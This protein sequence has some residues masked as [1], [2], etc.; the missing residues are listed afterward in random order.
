MP[1]R[2]EREG[3]DWVCST[4][5]RV[6][7][8]TRWDHLHRPPMLSTDV[9]AW[10]GGITS[11]LA[12]LVLCT[13]HRTVPQRIVCHWAFDGVRLAIIVYD[14]KH[15]RRDFPHSEHPPNGQVCEVWQTIG[16]LSTL[17]SCTKFREPAARYPCL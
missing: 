4:A 2:N 14:H 3:E 9:V 16:D 15:E 11:D 5:L 7:D 10:S 6:N 13:A 12:A 17:S 1:A 8:G